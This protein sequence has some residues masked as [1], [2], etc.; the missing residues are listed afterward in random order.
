MWI[1]PFQ[2]EKYVL[3]GDNLSSFNSL[4]AVINLIFYIFE[5]AELKKWDEKNFVLETRPVLAYT[6]VLER[7]GFFKAI[8]DFSH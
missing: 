6:K 4:V 7:N 1:F 3:L 2:I 8:F 5:M